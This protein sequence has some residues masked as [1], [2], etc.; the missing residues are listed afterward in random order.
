MVRCD[1]YGGAA[2]CFERLHDLDSK[3]RT[4][5][6]ESTCCKRSCAFHQSGMH[7]G[8]D[9]TNVVLSSLMARDRYLDVWKVW[10]W[11]RAASDLGSLPW[12]RIGMQ[13]RRPM[14]FKSHGLF[15][16][17]IAALRKHVSSHLC[18]PAL[19]TAVLFRLAIHERGR[20]RHRN[21][22][23]KCNRNTRSCLA[24]CHGVQ[25]GVM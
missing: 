7:Y 8:E 1:R 3:A 15:F 23:G 4:F 16:L 13:S 18:C 5:V 11:Q 9:A 24:L 19:V 21:G 12:R 25:R 10:L 14:R 17:A 22:Q 20:E 6:C 2:N